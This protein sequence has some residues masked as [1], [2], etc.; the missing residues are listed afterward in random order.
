[1][2]IDTKLKVV[3][4]NKARGTLAE[5][6]RKLKAL[7]IV[8][9]KRGKPI[10]ALVSMRNRDFESLALSTSPQF[11]KLIERGRDQIRR[12]ECISSEKVLEELGISPGKAGRI[13]KIK[14]AKGRICPITP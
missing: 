12:G 3:E 8:F 14:C 1:M 11:R 4:L 6:V 9:T 2:V 5:Y 7:P 10:V 13:R